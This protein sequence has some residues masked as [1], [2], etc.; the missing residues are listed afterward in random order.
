MLWENNVQDAAVP[1]IAVE[2]AEAAICR[3]HYEVQYSE[4]QNNTEITQSFSS[5]SYT[6]V[7]VFCL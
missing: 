1:A 7:Y 3:I 2:A 6:T 4:K 5:P